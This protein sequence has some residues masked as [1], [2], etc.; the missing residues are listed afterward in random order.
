MLSE[1]INASKYS[2]NNA[3]DVKINYDKIQPLIDEIGNFKYQHYLTKNPFGI[4]NLSLEEIVNFLLVYDAIDFS[5]WGDPKWI[6]DADGEALDG[7]IAL[8][9][10]MLQIFKNNG[11]NTYKFLSE[12]TKDEFGEYLKGNVEIPL[13]NE[14]YEIVRSI[15]KTVNAEMNGSFYN[16]I[17]H[18]LSDKELFDLI[19]SSF[20]SFKDER[21]YDERVIPFYKLAQLLTSDILHIIEFKTGNKVDYSHLVGCADYKIPQIMRSYGIL[22]YSDEL[23]AIVDNKEIITENDK[24]EVEIRASIIVVIDYIYNQLNG[25]ICRIDINDYVWGKGRDKGL[26]LKPYHLTRTTSY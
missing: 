18:I 8:L 20:P 13:F 1:I 23:T 9:Y 10:A 17:Q 6:I 19:N 5:F 7:G 22:E 14:R 15:A 11:T 16:H 4:M 12:M 3:K 26:V 2:K 25:L 21:T 24:Y